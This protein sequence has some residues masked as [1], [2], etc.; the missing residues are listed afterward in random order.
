[1]LI[2][3]LI[4]LRE[5][6]EA[7]LLVGIIAAYL[8]QTDRGQWLPSVWVGVALAAFLSL[9]VG[10]AMALVHAEFPQKQQELFEAA[11][12]LIAVGVLT[13]MVL[14]M[15]KAARSVRR[16]LHQSV[17]AALHGRA[18]QGW[19]LI[20]MAFLAVAREG[21][22]TVFFLLATVQQD[23]G[24]WA[25]AL[26]ALGGLVLAAGLGMAL[27]RGGIHLNLGRFF[28]VTGILIL[29]VAA[30]LLAGAVRSLH[31]AGLW[32]GLQTVVFDLSA[33]L[34][35]DSVLGMVLAGLLGYHDTPSLG[36]VLAY[37]GFLLP[38]L[39]LFVRG[40][41]PQDS[42]A[43]APSASL[44]SSRADGAPP[45]R[46]LALAAG[47]IAA[48]SLVGGGAFVLSMRHGAAQGGDSQTAAITLDG[49]TCSPD[50]LTLPAGR[51]TFVIHNAGRRVMEWEILQGVMVV[52]ERENIAPGTTQKMTVRLEPGR[53]AITC[54]LKSKFVA[55]LRGVLEVTASPQGQVAAPPRLVD[56]IAP[57]AEYR[58]YLHE[59]AGE[60]VDRAQAL[61]DAVKAGDGTAARA[62]LPAARK[63]HGHV[64]ALAGTDG[65]QLGLDRLRDALARPESGQDTNALADAVLGQ[66]QALQQHLDDMDLA[67]EQMVEAV[68]RLGGADPADLHSRLEGTAKIIDLLRP[69]LAK[70]D[71]ALL[72]RLD[73]R[74]NALLNNPD[75]AALSTVLN[76]L[77]EDAAVLR[78]ALG[79]S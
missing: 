56:L 24:G 58:F 2:A 63:A 13:S 68:G 42:V 4:M 5:G 47:A 52:E 38:A 66:A 6:L 7:A 11:V 76:A 1:M 78:V 48:L 12:G 35:V 32:N 71:P 53:Y 29:F 73:T 3:F 41:R 44:S 46:R 74:L 25:T 15:G 22:E 54:S 72:G 39:V 33:V 10:A 45:F 40:S 30:G 43:V 59:E 26:G 31:E 19:A 77:A 67:P 34:P 36:E 37:G 79:L 28:R 62:L 9:A 65:V 75:H 69:V 18:G 50:H 57:L 64:A 49:D 70:A 16:H 8:K 27:Y 21:L 61:S 14:W 17:D 51:T 20:G 60:L 23:A 55:D